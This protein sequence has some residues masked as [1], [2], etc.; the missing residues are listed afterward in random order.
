MLV[1]SHCANVVT[2]VKYLILGNRRQ[3]VQLL[4]IT[5]HTPP[6]IDIAMVHIN[7]SL[8]ETAKGYY[9]DRVNIY[10]M[11]ALIAIIWNRPAQQPK[12]T[13][14]ESKLYAE[15]YQAYTDGIYIWHPLNIATWP[16]FDF[17]ADVFIQLLC[18]IHRRIGVS[19][20][21]AVN[22][23]FCTHFLRWYLRGY[24]LRKNVH[25]K[26]HTQLNNILVILSSAKLGKCCPTGCSSS[27]ETYN[28]V[29]VGI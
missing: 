20:E 7:T 4:S 2:C 27:F 15:P 12:G 22:L 18:K 29:V 5:H 25:D 28:D 10:F 9:A 6:H 13:A 8:P 21:V 17:I 1:R 19:G 11:A 16:Q 24:W 26:A 14:V 23:G 3:L